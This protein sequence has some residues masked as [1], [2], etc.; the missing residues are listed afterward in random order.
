MALLESEFQ[1]KCSAISPL[2]VNISV[3]FSA[4]RKFCRS[5][6]SATSQKAHHF[7]ADSCNVDQ[8]QEP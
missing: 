2:P 8:Y 6:I 4:V 5:L 1:I 7:S 3:H